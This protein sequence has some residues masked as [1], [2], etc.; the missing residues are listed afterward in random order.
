MIIENSKI[1]WCYL[2][3]LFFTNILSTA[4]HAQSNWQDFGET[5][6]SLSSSNSADQYTSLTVLMVYPMSLI[7]TVVKVAN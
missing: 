2:S 3:L 7:A 5:N 6:S 1:F 4:I